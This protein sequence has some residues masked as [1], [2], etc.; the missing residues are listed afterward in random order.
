[1]RVRWGE[2]LDGG[3]TLAVL[4]T[5]GVLCALTDAERLQLIPGALVRGTGVAWGTDFHG[6]LW[7]AAGAI[8]RGASPYPPAKLTVLLGMPQP[9]YWPPLMAVLT[10]PLAHLPFA[11]A[12][13]AWNAT[14]IASFAGGLWL[15]GLRDWRI[16][17]LALLSFPFQESLYW[18]Q[19]EGIYFLLMAIAW[20]HRDSWRGGV[21]LGVVIAAKLVAWPLLVWLLAS[22]RYSA[23]RAAVVT[24]V[25]LL[26]ASWGV[27][28]F[29]GMFSYPHLLSLDGLIFERSVLS[30]SAVSLFIHVG[31]PPSASMLA[32]VAVSL[33]V[34]GAALARGR[35]SETSWFAVAVLASLLWSPLMW[36]HYLVVIFAPLCVSHPRSLRVWLVTAGFWV[37]VPSQNYD[38]RAIVTLVTAGALTVLA[39]R[40]QAALGTSGHGSRRGV[41]VVPPYR[42]VADQIV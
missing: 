24:T 3:L 12:I 20:R 37:W 32:S 9:F 2:L 22:R 39:A 41:G 29:Q 5:L 38:V 31:M 8:L 13:T 28:D 17:A 18:G 35:G 19:A 1:V 34:G 10:V 26:L 30:M 21:A 6:G 15:F 42:P 7:P 16:Y 11:S 33:L 4:L 23:A 40:P 14:C 36:T 27:I 25:L